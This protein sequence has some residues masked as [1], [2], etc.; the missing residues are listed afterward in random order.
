MHL[1]SA[2]PTEI[3]A[4]RAGLPFAKGRKKRL[5]Q[6]IYL[7][8][9]SERLGNWQTEFDVPDCIGKLSA[10]PGDSKILTAPYCETLRNA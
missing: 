5:P 3:K 4:R 8:I 9:P 6:T 1:A 7:I 10:L 2:I